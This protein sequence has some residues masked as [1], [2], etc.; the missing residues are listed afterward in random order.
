MRTKADIYTDIQYASV[1]LIRMYSGSN[2]TAKL[3]EFRRLNRSM[4]IINALCY[5]I[6]KIPVSLREDAFTTHDLEFIN[7][8][9]PSF[10]NDTYCRNFT[11]LNALLIEFYSICPDDMKSNL[12][13]HP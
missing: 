8:A 9:I 1:L 12:K 4:R 11:E 3:W 7:H 6:H 10:L 13:W 2:G 5:L